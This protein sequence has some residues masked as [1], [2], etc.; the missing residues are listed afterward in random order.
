ME[1]KQMNKKELEQFLVSN[2]Y[3]DIDF[4][5]MTCYDTIA[6][7]KTDI[8]DAVFEILTDDRDFC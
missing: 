2:K 5:S 1:I 6:D 3:I 8:R 7:E 4:E